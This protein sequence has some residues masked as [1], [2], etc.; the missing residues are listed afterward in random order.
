MQICKRCVLDENFPGIRFDNDGI[1]SICRTSEGSRDQNEQKEKSERRFRELISLH[2]GKSSYD[3]LVAF[4]GGKDSTY[5][6]ELMKN[7]YGLNI[8]AYSFNNWFQS[9]AALRNIQSVVRS[10][11]IDHVTITPAYEQFRKL[12]LLAASR[13]LYTKKALERASA[14]CITCISLIR[15]IGFKMAREKKIPFVVLGMTPGQASV[16][17]SLVRINGDMVIKM[18]HAAFDSL[19]AQGGMDFLKPYLLEKSDFGAEDVPTYNVNPLSFSGYDEEA[20][21]SAIRRLGWIKPQD[22][23]PNSTNCLLNAYAN[24]V[25]LDRYGFNPYAF[26]IAGLVREGFVSREE[27][28][29]KLSSLADTEALGAVRKKLGIPEQDSPDVPCSSG[30][31]GQGISFS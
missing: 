1:C 11:N 23:D 26:E 22:T 5:V 4:S 20:I 18:Q 2:K 6:L 21:V 27:G 12:I 10:L 7:R 3:C 15:Y 29:L 8:L 25:H 9:E 19:I 14:I 30:V 17:T 24:Q 13:E 16:K 31:T 28:L